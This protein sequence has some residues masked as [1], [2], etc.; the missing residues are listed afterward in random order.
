[1]ENEKAR[2]RSYLARPGTNI[3]MLADVA[4][5]SRPPVTGADRDGWQPSAKTLAKV[6]AA[7]VRLERAYIATIIDRESDDGSWRDALASASC[8][9]K[10]EG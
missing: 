3:K 5:L 1:M 10:Q 7:V 9:I 6:Y 2:I 8:M 4:G